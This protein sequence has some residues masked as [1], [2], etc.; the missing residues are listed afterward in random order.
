[1]YY[2]N[3]VLDF[4]ATKE[5][6]D[7]LDNLVSI[8]TEL[9]KF[10]INVEDNLRISKDYLEIIDEKNKYPFITNWDLSRVLFYKNKDNNRERVEHNLQ[11]AS[12]KIRNETPK[13]QRF[14]IKN[15]RT[16]LVEKEFP[17]SSELIKEIELVINEKQESFYELKDRD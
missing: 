7:T 1:M 8:R 3:K 9:A 15:L 12:Q 17:Y 16:E 10:G 5:A 14:F 11:L 6:I 2:Y 4:K 13:M